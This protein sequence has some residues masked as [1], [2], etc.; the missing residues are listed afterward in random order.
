M[1]DLYLETKNGNLPIN[2][3][4]I[5]KYNLKKG[6]ISPFTHNR[7]VGKNGDFHL[8]VKVQP[9][10]S[11]EVITKNPDGG[12]LISDGTVELENGITLSASEI[13]DISEGAD[14]YDQH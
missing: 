14:S 7:I 8:E 2:Q 9:E 1:D 6:T 11:E 10:A 12:K 4:I 13:I 5:E 3:G